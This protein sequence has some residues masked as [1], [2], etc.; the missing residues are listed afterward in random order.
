MGTGRSEFW[1]SSDSNTMIGPITT[2]PHTYQPY[3][4]A[5]PAEYNNENGAYRSEMGASNGRGV[6]GAFGIRTSMNRGPPELDGVEPKDWNLDSKDGWDE[7][8][9]ISPMSATD[10]GATRGRMESM[11]IDGMRFEMVGESKTF[12]MPGDETFQP[13]EKPFG[14]R[15][16]RPLTAGLGQNLPNI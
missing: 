16:A 14:S 15:K 13:N 3:T 9:D 8:M 6:M 4:T 10:P 7:K 5:P 2:G 11:R 1:S 12:E